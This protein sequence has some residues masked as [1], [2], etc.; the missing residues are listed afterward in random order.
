M[1]LFDFVCFYSF[2]MYLFIFV[3]F[4]LF[5]YVFI[6]FCMYLFVF[7]SIFL[8]LTVSFH[9]AQKMSFT[10]KAIILN[11]TDNYEQMPIRVRE[12]AKLSW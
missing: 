2:F 9:T 7:S 3:C 12:A 1:Y 4:Y 5:L 6:W 11:K 10:S 8:F